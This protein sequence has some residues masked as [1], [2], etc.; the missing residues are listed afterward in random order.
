MIKH[1]G[2]IERRLNQQRRK[3]MAK[4]QIILISIILFAVLACL[5]IVKAG[6]FIDQSEAKGL[7]LDMDLSEK[8]YNS[9]TK[10]FTDQTPYSNHG[11]SNND[12]S[13]KFTTDRM[14][15]SNG[16][17][18]FNGT[19]DYVDCG[20]DESLNI[21]DAITI[22][23]WVKVLDNNHRV[24][25]SKYDIDHVKRSWLL[26]TYGGKAR[27]YIS[28]DGSHYE[29]ATNDITSITWQHVVGTFEGGNIVVYVNGVSGTPVSASGIYS[30]DVTTYIGRFIY[31]SENHWFFNGTIDE[32][33]IYNR[34]LSA[35][36]IKA[37][38]EKYKPKFQVA[39]GNKGLVLD[40][41][42]SEKYYNSATKRFTDQ[43]PYSNHG[44][45]ANAA[46]F[47]TD[48]M[49][50]SN[51][52][53]T[54]NGTDDYVDCGSH[55]SL[56][57]TDAIT[58]EAWV[59]NNDWNTRNYIFSKGYGQTTGDAAW[60]LYGL[61]GYV[62]FH[63]FTTYEHT[64]VLTSL[65]NLVWYHIV[66]TYDK[67]AGSENLKLY[68]NAEIKNQKTLT[69]TIYEV[70]QPVRIGNIGT[71]LGND[72]YFNGTIDE[73][74]IYNRALSAEEIKANYEKYKAK[75][76][77]GSLKK[78]LVLDMPLS[79]KYIKGGAAG[80]EILTDLTPYS[81][82]GQNY[83]ATIGTD[84]A[85]FDGTDDY[86]DCGNDSSLDITDA[87]TIEAW[88]KLNSFVTNHDDAIV[89]KAD[90]QGDVE[91]YVLFILRNTHEA[92]F[93]VG[94]SDATSGVTGT[95]A[96]STNE[97]YH[98]VGVRSGATGYIYVNGVEEN[99]TAFTTG[100]LSNSHPVIIGAWYD[101]RISPP[102]QENHGLNGTIDEVR[103]YNRALSASE[104][105][106]LYLAGL[107][108]HP[109]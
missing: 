56:N 73:V 95:S 102:V 8:Y 93:Q 67:D 23:A 101:T 25:A 103:I 92:K 13:S 96:L 43:T 105:Q 45:S 65:S 49:G 81:N 71:F 90:C 63:I 53:M 6:V 97:W 5:G 51:G 40:M 58:I 14:G 61:D 54:F 72:Y 108:R 79:S 41:D 44:T 39:E 7:V 89:M 31:S 10:R 99:S 109:K 26:E 32:V 55:E 77:V 69:G 59:K 91:R 11:T 64:E 24:I 74:R 20:N 62:R 28:S 106:Q 35:E 30:S 87:I 85:T 98:I 57:I 83:G 86:V 9:A 80:S 1:L 34:A 27:F 12:A 84:Y 29:F 76:S 15:N 2:S 107:P 36:E 19:D 70:T 68:V 22:E 46:S 66:A 3:T 33:R 50:N 75:F 82:D 47:T 4:K 38:Y 60:W 100:D 42:L 94:D 37:N 18:T 52:A 21:T 48:R 104:I 17:M 16:A 78:G 88:V